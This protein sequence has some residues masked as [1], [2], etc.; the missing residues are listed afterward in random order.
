MTWKNQEKN[1]EI[2]FENDE[3][4]MMKIPYSEPQKNSD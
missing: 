4:K 2:S 3:R 1:D